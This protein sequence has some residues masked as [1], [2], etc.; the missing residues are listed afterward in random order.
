M[1]TCMTAHLVKFVIPHYE[2]TYKLSCPGLNLDQVERL[3]FLSRSKC[4]K[5]LGFLEDALG[6]VDKVLKFEPFSPKVNL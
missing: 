6:E 3:A 2:T 5:K 4:F 1:L